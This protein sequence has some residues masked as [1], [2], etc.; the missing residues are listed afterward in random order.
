MLTWPSC[1]HK[2]M[3]VITLCIIIMHGQASTNFTSII[4]GLM[5]SSTAYLTNVVSSTPVQK[6]KVGLN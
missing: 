3:Q 1:I 2:K 6:G 4:I 5:A